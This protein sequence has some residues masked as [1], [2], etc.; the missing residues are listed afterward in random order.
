MRPKKTLNRSQKNKVENK[1]K[2]DLLTALGRIRGLENEIATAIRGME[3]K[4][5]QLEC[6]TQFSALLN[7]TLD[8]AVVRE[9]ALEATCK[10]L[11]CETASLYLVDWKTGEL[12]WDTA[13]GEAGKTLKRNFRLPIN[14]RSIAGYVAMSGES[15]IVNDVE[16]DPHH[17]KKA[18]EKS[19]FRTKSMVCVPL[20]SKDRVIGV[21]QALNKLDSVP[22]RPSRHAWADFYETDLRLLQTLSNQVAIAVENSLLYTDLKRSFYE[23]VQALAETIE[24]KDRYTGGHIKRVVKYSSIIARHL[25][26][27]SEQIERIQLGALLHD[28]G[29]IGIEDKILKKHSHLDP[30]ERRLMQQHPALGYDIM[31]RVQGLRDV[32]AGMRYHHE[33]WDG[34]GYPLGLKGEEIPLIARIIAVADTYDAIISNR[35]YR[36]GFA[37]ERAFDEITSNKCA[38]FDPVVVEAFV[39]AYEAEEMDNSARPAQIQK[40]GTN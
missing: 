21:L 33:R 3:E 34:N 7:S 39:E 28:I 8:P 35:P 30:E 37:P 19:S 31:R 26:L 17:F 22:S 1:T 4:V 20:R 32:I 10:L 14:D 12:Y 11:A 36:K 29:K 16:N 23:T 38:Q 6:L 9:K 2:D 27:T 24:K 5:R 25:S 13:L 18:A 40:T 15:V